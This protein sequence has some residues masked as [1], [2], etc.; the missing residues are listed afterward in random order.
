[1]GVVSNVTA[2]ETYNKSHGNT[3]SIFC[4][5]QLLPFYCFLDFDI[6]LL[7]AIICLL[8]WIVSELEV[9]ASD[10]LLTC[11]SR[12]SEYKNDSTFSNLA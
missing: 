10:Y 4:Q 8:D 3:L 11:H 5:K 1:M 9:N 2:V 6:L 12:A 7:V